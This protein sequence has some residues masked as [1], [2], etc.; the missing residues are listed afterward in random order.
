[1]KLKYE[2]YYDNKYVIVEDG[3]LSNPKM[4]EGRL[5][6]AVVLKSKNDDNG[7][8]ELILVH[9]ETP[10]GD[11]IVN[12]ILLPQGLIKRDRAFLHVKFT[13]PMEVEF[14]IE[15]R[16]RDHYSLI[17]AILQS[18]GL[19]IGVGE[20]GEKVSMKINSADMV[21]IEVPDTGFHDLWNKLFKET[22]KKK[23]RKQGVPKK[24]LNEAV[25]DHINHIREILQL[26]REIE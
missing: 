20:K 12:W 3:L 5:I 25:Q 26:R 21:L 18:R 23:F 4:G 11:V 8:K 15:F 17:D 9:K 16:I 13:K 24:Q 1:M 19:S 2:S 6:P 14:Q 10:P 7:L 22:L